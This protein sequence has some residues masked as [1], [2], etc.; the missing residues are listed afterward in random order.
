MWVRPDIPEYRT[1][2]SYMKDNKQH[3]TL[4]C[5]IARE[6]LARTGESQR[7]YCNQDFAY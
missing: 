4:G 6:N 5:R 2:N 7:A 1:Y 3:I